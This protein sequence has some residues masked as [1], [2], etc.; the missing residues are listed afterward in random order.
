MIQE[1]YAIGNY[2]E[3]EDNPLEITS[4]HRSKAIALMSH[5]SDGMSFRI[6]TL[7]V[8]VSIVDRYLINLIS[9][10]KKAPCLVTLGVVSMLIAAKLGNS[11]IASFRKLSNFLVENHGIVIHKKDF[12]VLERRVLTVLDF[13][14]DY[15]TPLTFLERYQRIFDL[16]L[17]QNHKDIKYISKGT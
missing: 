14:L 1:E 4:D 2:L 6:E 12:H 9:L 7:Y 10:D 17:T 13:S 16:D 5:M 3:N 8:A 11:K 15:I